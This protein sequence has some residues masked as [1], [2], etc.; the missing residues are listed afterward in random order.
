MTSKLTDNFYLPQIAPQ[1]YDLV[2]DA[3]VI[4]D[5]SFK[6]KFFDTTDKRMKFATIYSPFTHLKSG[7]TFK[8]TNDIV[9]TNSVLIQLVENYTKIRSVYLQDI[10]TK[11]GVG[12]LL[13]CDLNVK[14]VKETQADGTNKWWG[15]NPNLIW[16]GKIYAANK[17]N[18]TIGDFMKHMYFV[19]QYQA[20]QSGIYTVIG[21]R[22]QRFFNSEKQP[23]IQR[24]NDVEIKRNKP[25]YIYGAPERK[26]NT[27][28]R[29]SIVEDCTFL[30]TTT[31][32]NHDRSE[33]N[34][35][36]PNFCFNYLSKYE[37]QSRRTCSTNWESDDIFFFPSTEIKKGNTSI[38]DDLKKN[39]SFECSNDKY[40]DWLNTSEGIFFFDLYKD[41]P[42]KLEE[43]EKLFDKNVLEIKKLVEDI[44]TLNEVVENEQLN[45]TLY[46]DSNLIEETFVQRVNKHLQLYGFISVPFANKKGNN[47]ITLSN[48]LQFRVNHTVK[49]EHLTL[50][51][52]YLEKSGSLDTTDEKI[53][54]LSIV[55]IESLKKKMVNIE[56]E[57]TIE[58]LQKFEKYQK[59]NPIDIKI[60]DNEVIRKLTF[61]ENHRIQYRFIP[62]SILFSS[63][64]QKETKVIF[65][66]T[67]GLNQAH[68]VLI[69]NKLFKAIGVIYTNE[70][71]N[72]DKIKKV[73]SNW[74]SCKLTNSR[75]P[76]P[77]KHLSFIFDTTNLSSLLSFGLNL[78]DQDGKEISFDDSEEKVPALNFAIQI[79]S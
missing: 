67:T 2:L 48:L 8:G 36:H 16:H 38:N 73:S 79:I 33:L 6:Y 27:F 69:N 75:F 41:I 62:N 1:R 31:L 13:Y 53:H 56:R 19:R 52:A 74:V 59:L 3:K 50:E 34:K 70:I 26:P 71:E 29:G 40:K 35:L 4:D 32:T 51:L 61:K 12:M 11:W 22:F 5:N 39:L 28:T 58:G 65:L 72:W 49:K 44:G 10:N 18:F 63:S 47:L 23:F 68:D 54:N 21:T 20:V 77:A 43:C 25:F 76:H 15:T 55:C 7:L 24:E 60:T 37:S 78:I 66:T 64:I 14:L 46:D 57:V 17:T 45:L 9:K 42:D 30:G